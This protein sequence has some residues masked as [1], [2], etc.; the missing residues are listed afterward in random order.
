M[1]STAL[2]QQVTQRL[3]VAFRWQPEL[4]LA[5]LESGLTGTFGAAAL[6]AS[7]AGAKSPQTRWLSLV[8]L[9]ARELMQ[10]G[11]VPV[12]DVP[13]II[14]IAPD[15]LA[16]D[17]YRATVNVPYIDAAAT[18]AWRRV[19]DAATAAC[20]QAARSTSSEPLD[21]ESLDRKVVVALQKRIPGGKST[22]PVLRA[23]HALGI[24]FIHLGMGAYQL[25]WGSKA[26]RISRGSNGQDSA[27]GSRL[28][29]SKA[30]TAALLR[31]AGLPAPAHVVVRN[32]EQALSAAASL[33]WPVVVKPAD[34]ER[35]EGVMVD[36]D[37][38]EKLKAAF[39]AS[40]ALS[41]ARQ[42]LVERQV[43]GV[44][45]RIFIARGEVLYVVKRL[46]MSVRGD[47]VHT[48]AQLVE[49]ELERQRVKAPWHRSEIRE[50]DD[51]AIAALAREGMTPSCV[52]P[53]GVL[54]PLRRL[55]ST[56]D[57]GVDEDV[58]ARIHP[59]N[60]LIAIQAARLFGLDMAGIDLITTDISRP[61]FETGSIINEV[62][63]SPV[64]G[65]GEI[66]RG[67]LPGF[68]RRFVEGDG[69]IPVEVFV[70]GE[71]AFEAALVAKEKRA[72]RGERCWLTSASRTIDGTG[73]DVHLAIGGLYGR[74]CALVLDPTVDSL[75]LVV[76]A[77]A[78]SATGLPLIGLPPPVFVA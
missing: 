2:P 39:V 13:S 27:I 58:T 28:S 51:A 20:V 73:L 49:Q 16:G 46:P 54:A 26:R 61:W 42:V 41:L 60:R 78:W 37:G 59:E 50:L 36:V 55:E 19:I 24:P 33:G 66:S 45:H 64:L 8:L 63:F 40:L 1:Q 76:Q 22:I 18:D 4:D 62:N 72:A 67:Y 53:A 5:R 32:A 25:G 57:G 70:G 11:R 71:A 6:P 77:D 34:R 7:P 23:A 74:T 35:G 21:L 12:F 17:R 44:C 48:V 68:L 29:A 65:A 10:A 15:P 52:P 69:R 56:A 9:L 47:G 3:T 31:M 43:A 38:D 14:E 75:V 30:S